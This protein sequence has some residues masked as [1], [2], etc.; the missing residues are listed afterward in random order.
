MTKNISREALYELVWTKPMTGVLKFGAVL[1]KSPRPSR[2]D[3]PYPLR[4]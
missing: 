1:T 2:V 3:T 4:T